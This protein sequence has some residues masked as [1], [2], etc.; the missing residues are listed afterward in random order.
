MGDPW[1]ISLLFFLLCHSFFSVP[2]LSTLPRSLALCQYICCLVSPTLFR[3]LSLP[4]HPPVLYSRYPLQP[5]RP[6]L[7]PLLG[8]ERGFCLPPA[9]VTWRHAGGDSESDEPAV[10]ATLPSQTC[11]CVLG[12]NCMWVRRTEVVCVCVERESKRAPQS[13]FGLFLCIMFTCVLF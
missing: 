3:S 12:I 10:S 5:Q 4:L 11:V 1:A 6:D 7:L 9:A 2:P 13:M 8:E